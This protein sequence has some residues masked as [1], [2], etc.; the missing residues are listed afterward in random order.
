MDAIIGTGKKQISKRIYEIISTRNVSVLMSDGVNINV[1]I[2]RPDSNEKFPALVGLSPVNLEYQRDRVWPS[3]ARSRRIRGTPDANIESGPTDFFVR[4]GY[5]HIIGSVRGT[6]R[7]GGAYQYQSPVDNRDIYEII[8]W[9]AKQSW[10]NG[11]VGMIGIA[12]FAANQPKVATL[13]PPHLKTV[14]PLFAFWDNYRHFWWTGGILSNGFL[15]WICSLV[16]LDVHTEKSVLLE[17]LGEEGFKKV[18]ADALVDKDISAD[19]GLVDVLKNPN[20]LGN[21]SLLDI[22]LHPTDGPYWQEC[23]G[24]DFNMIKVPAYFGAAGHRPGALYH[25]SDLKGPKKVV[26]GPPSYVDRP[27][28]QYAWELLRWY[29]HWLKG[30]DTGIMDEPAV[31]IFVQG[32]NEWKMGDD[33]PFPETKWIPFNL[34]A[35]RSLCEIEPWPEAPSASYDDAPGNRGSLKYYSAPIVENTEVV[36]PVVLNLYASCRGTDMNLFVSLWDADP[37]GKETCLT[38]GWLKGSHR[39]LD[40]KRSKPWHPV[41]THTNPKPLVPGQVYQVSIPLFPTANLFKAGHKIVLKIS[42]ADDE[43]ENLFQMGMYHLCSQ[44]SNTIT[45]YHNAQYPSHLLLPITRGNIVGTYASG[46][47]ISLKT[48]EF[49]ELA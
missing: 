16:N 42:S 48:K 36:G 29:D 2:F 44:T 10:C 3:A 37:E 30:I 41:H 1:D 8:E 22:L 15:K 47:D 4:R 24:V 18:I 11:N 12:E 43:P 38:R 46:G 27:F 35:N 9:A 20:R 23:A 33:W 26:F 13:Q 32:A 31:K 45:V 34:H 49:M 28:Y 6:G 25:W 19:P 17:E 14:A 40:P 39:E 5:V 21:A 7:S